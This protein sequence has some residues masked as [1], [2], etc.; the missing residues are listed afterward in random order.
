[1]KRLLIIVLVC[2][3]IPCAYGDTDAR[4]L[5]Q[6]FNK[7]IA[8]IEEAG[9]KFHRLP[10]GSM[11]PSFNKDDFVMVMPFRGPL[12]RGDVITFRYPH[13]ES[14]I[15][16]K[17]VIGIA[18]DKISYIDKRLTVN[19]KKLPTIEIHQDGWDKTTKTH[20][21]L[22]RY[23]ESIDQTHYS[24]LLNPNQG[25]SNVSGIIVPPDRYFVMGDNRDHSNDSRFWGFLPTHNIEG[26]VVLTMTHR[27]LGPTT[28][29]AIKWR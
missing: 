2:A 4:S 6:S 21:G 18:G 13:D 16:F 26:I 23:G 8:Q 24:I 7:A 10:S 25:S 1:M 14:K 27:G 15:L 22:I 17:R 12:Q 9:I 11:L 28:K 3:L 19:G 20:Y 29:E 5:R